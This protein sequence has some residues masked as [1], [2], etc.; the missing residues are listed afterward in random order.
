[1]YGILELWFRIG[2]YGGGGVRVNFMV[3]FSHLP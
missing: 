1:M 3:S 2:A